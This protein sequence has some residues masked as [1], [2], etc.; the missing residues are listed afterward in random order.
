VILP[1]AAYTEKNGLYVNTEGRVQ[2][3]FRAVFPKGEAKEDWAILR[4]LPSGWAPSC[5][6]TAWTSCAPSCSPTIRPSAASTMCR[7]RRRRWTSAPRAKGEL[8]DAPFASAV[9][10][11]PDQTH[12]PRQR[13]HGR[14]ARRLGRRKIAAE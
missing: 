5:P 1:G 14:C 2:L 11:S 3:G 6:T 8:S 13:D 9:K 4:A 7:K 12:R 10:T